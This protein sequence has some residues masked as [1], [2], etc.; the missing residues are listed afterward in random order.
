[1]G[2]HFAGVLEFRAGTRTAADAA[3]AIGCE[4]AQI[5]KS[6]VFRDADTGAAVLVLCAG[7]NTVDAERLRLVKA[8]AEFVR[9]VTGYAIGGVPP[10]GWARP[11]TRTV[12]DRDLLGYTE[13]WAAA[14]TPRS[15]FP[16]SPA[17]LVAR[18]GGEVATVAPA[19]DRG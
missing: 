14:G 17:E 2:E 8:D 10:W 12:I 1:M 9:A 13:I 6:L 5:V 3:A 16:L 11:P 7:A 15:V 19:R 4:V 18:T